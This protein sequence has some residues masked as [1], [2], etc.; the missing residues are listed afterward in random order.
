M[1]PGG[2]LGVVSKSKDT[3]LRLYNN[4]DRYN[5][6]VFIATQMSVA[7]GGGGRGGT[8][9]PGGRGGDALGAGRGG[10]RGEPPPDGRGRF[11]QP[12]G[13]RV[14]T[15]ADSEG[16]AWGPRVSLR[17]AVASSLFHAPVARATLRVAHS[18]LITASC[19]A[20]LTWVI[21]WLSGFGW[22]RFVSRTT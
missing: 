19:T 11:G 17:R 15:E 12:Q 3:S 7:A 14:A 16:L 10:R 4:R 2:I 18:S 20:G 21:A 13:I 6:W 9:A 5:E 22:I 1:A 8:Q